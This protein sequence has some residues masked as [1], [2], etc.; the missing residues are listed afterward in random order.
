MGNLFYNMMLFG[1]C[2]QLSCYLF[3]A[4]NVTGNLIQFPL[5]SAADINN[6]NNMFSINLWTFLIG[7][8]GIAI[9][10][11]SLLMRSGTYAIYA[12]LISAIGVFFNVVKGFVFA[13]PNVISALFPGSPTGPIT[14]VVGVIVM[15]AG[16]IY[17]FELAIQRRAS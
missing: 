16:F 14:Y 15:F 13:V 10:V 1:I 8:A 12:L 7:G 4:F 5:G 2:V 9:S 6:L 17:L 11:V 3:W